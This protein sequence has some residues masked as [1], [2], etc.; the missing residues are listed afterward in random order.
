MASDRGAADG[1]Q[2]GEA[3]AVGNTSPLAS[4]RGNNWAL[5]KAT[6]TATGITRPIYVRCLPDQL[7]ILPERGDSSSTKVVP[8]RGP[9]V[10]SIDQFVSAIW[11]HMDQWGMAVANGYWKPVLHVNVARG[12]EDRFEELQSLMEGSGVEVRREQR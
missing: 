11:Q 4:T 10:D 2:A 1:P 6:V 12:A 7:L 9:L 3:T 8:A 5:P